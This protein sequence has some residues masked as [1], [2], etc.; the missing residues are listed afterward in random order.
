MCGVLFGLLY[1]LLCT[2][3]Q[4]LTKAARYLIQKPNVTTFKT[5]LKALNH[6]LYSHFLYMLYEKK[7]LRLS[8]EHCHP[9]V[10]SA[11]N[12][13]SVLA[14]QYTRKYSYCISFV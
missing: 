6:K 7:I 10:I 14:Y 12:G 11:R 5:F 4:N 3:G 9:V 1:R 13:G 2:R 8:A